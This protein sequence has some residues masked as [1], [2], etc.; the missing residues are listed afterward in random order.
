MVSIDPLKVIQF[1]E[2]ELYSVLQNAIKI[3]SVKVQEKYL[4]T[5]TSLFDI[6]TGEEKKVTFTK[7]CP[8]GCATF[9]VN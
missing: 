8:R 3:N 7:K 4:M 9:Q 1:E 5:K 2:S 6:N